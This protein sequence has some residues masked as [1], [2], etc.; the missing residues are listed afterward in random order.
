MQSGPEDD[1]AGNWICSSNFC[2]TSCHDKKLFESGPDKREYH[3]ILLRPHVMLLQT[4]NAKILC[5]LWHEHQ[6]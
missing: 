2:L 4:A 3:S 6:N 1:H 5:L